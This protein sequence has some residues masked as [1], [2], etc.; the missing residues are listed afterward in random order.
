MRYK[1][2]EREAFQV[3]GIR[4]ELS[5]GTGEAGIPG[6]PPFWEEAHSEG[7]V[8]ALIPLLNGEMKGLLGITGQYNEEKNTIHYWIAAEHKGKVPDEFISFE[9]PASKWVVFE[10]KGPIP[11]AMVQTWSQIYSAWFPNNGY[12]Q[13]S[14]PSIE[15]YL[16]SNLDS[17][18]SLNEI[19]VA[20][21]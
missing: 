10:V 6:I 11:E 19:W 14:M 12:K 21:E 15:A 17:P 9:V 20:I 13:A 3:V 8:E 16:D 5:C 4:R 2:V 1:I 7:I 18:N